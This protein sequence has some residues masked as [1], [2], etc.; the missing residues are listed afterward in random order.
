MILPN[1]QV[2]AI[3][4]ALIERLDADN[5]Y[6]FTFNF[7][8]VKAAR[9]PIHALLNAGY[10]QDDPDD[11]QDSFWQMA[12]GEST[13]VIQY[14]NKA[15]AAFLTLTGILD[16]IFETPPTDVAQPM[17]SVHAQTHSK[18]EDA[19]LARLLE[20]AAENSAVLRKNSIT[21][22]SQQLH[23]FLHEAVNI[24]RTADAKEVQ[25]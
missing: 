8:Q 15:P 21:F 18:D 20:S 25:S 14:F 3:F 7:S 19:L 2:D 9:E 6:N 17:Q 16:E 4:L 24:V 1:S 5:G 13:E 11:L 12:A 22:T 23:A 10:F